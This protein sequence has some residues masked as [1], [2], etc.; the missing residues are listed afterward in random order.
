MPKDIK[1]EDKVM[2][3]ELRQLG[4]SYSQIQ[5]EVAIPKSTIALWAK[6]IELDDAAKSSLRERRKITAQKNA[7]SRK[8][9]AKKLREDILETSA[10]SITEISLKEFWLMGIMMLW[11]RYDDKKM[12]LSR[13]EAVSF[14]SSD[15]Q[16]LQFMMRWFQQVGKLKKH[17]IYFDVFSKKNNANNNNEVIR[18][19]SKILHVKPGELHRHYVYPDAMENAHQGTVRRSNKLAHSGMGMIRMRIASSSYLAT[20]IQGWLRGIARWLHK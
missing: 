1:K 4:Y 9:K 18:Y 10:A 16:L 6:T 5:N 3:L 20:Q 8:S 14:M 19:W 12:S 15:P 7:E 11:R 13:N 2:V 17:E